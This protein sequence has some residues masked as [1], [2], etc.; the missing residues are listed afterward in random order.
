[1]YNPRRSER[2]CRIQSK[3]GRGEKEDEKSNTGKPFLTGRP[4]FFQPTGTIALLRDSFIIHQTPQ[5]EPVLN[6]NVRPRR[7]DSSQKFSKAVFVVAPDHPRSFMK[8]PGPFC[9]EQKLLGEDCNVDVHGIVEH[10]S[11]ISSFFIT[12]GSRLATDQFY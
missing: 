10:Q 12:V 7:L 4:S 1:V 8:N 5:S 11:I 2:Q 9:R 3:T 6:S